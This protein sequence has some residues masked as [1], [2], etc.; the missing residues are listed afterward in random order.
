MINRH[1][2]RLAS[3]AFATSGLI[4][5]LLSAALLPTT[6]VHGQA[7][8][9]QNQALAQSI[10]DLHLYH[11]QDANHSQHSPVAHGFAVLIDQQGTFL[12]SRY[13]LGRPQEMTCLLGRPN[14][15]QRT[16][17][18]IVA[19]DTWSDL[20]IIKLPDDL[21]DETRKAL[22]EDAIV[23]PLQTENCQN[24]TANESLFTFKQVLDT[25]DVDTSFKKV[26]G[27]VKT[28]RPLPEVMRQNRFDLLGIYSGYQY[29][30]LWELQLQESKIY[31][32]GLPVFDADDNLRGLTTARIEFAIASSQPACSILVFSPAHGRILS[33]LVQG[34]TP[35]YGFLGVQPRNLSANQETQTNLKGIQIVDVATNSPA[36]VAGLQFTDIITHI[37]D[38]PLTDSDSFWQSF[39]WQQAGRQLKIRVTRGAL[40]DGPVTEFEATCQLS[41]RRLDLALPSIRSAPVDSWQGLQVEYPFAIENHQT[42]QSNISPDGCVVSSFVQLNSPAWEAGLRPRLV[43]LHVNGSKVSSPAEFFSKVNQSAS[44]TVL[45]S[46]VEPTTGDSFQYSLPKQ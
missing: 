39:H 3:I 23:A 43:I 30:G 5:M 11:Q 24:P 44:E 20:A 36:D 6:P 29:G 31:S 46:G 9:D 40:K 15:Q 17:V 12:T 2:Q 7:A 32:S 4:A 22:L 27:S 37:D 41:K 25:D 26:S 10:Y 13:L 28:I 19:A 21:D 1:N 8:T 16:P 18:Q 14:S 45:I 33:T 34:K 38:Q 42:I 35:D